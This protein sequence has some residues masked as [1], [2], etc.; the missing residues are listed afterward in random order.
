MPCASLFDPGS[1]ALRDSLRADLVSVSCTHRKLWLSAR[2]D[3]PDGIRA[4][5]GVDGRRVRRADDGR[6]ATVRPHA[7]PTAMSQVPGLPIAACRRGPVSAP[8]AASEESARPTRG[9][10]SSRLVRP[11]S[12]GPGLICINDF[13]TIEPGPGAGTSARKVRAPIIPRSCPTRFPTE[14]WSYIL[15]GM[16]VGVGMVDSLPVGLSA[17]Y[18]VH[19]P[20]HHRRGLGTWNILCL[21]DEARRRGLPHLYLGY[22]VADCLSLAYKSIVPSL[23]NPRTGWRVAPLVAAVEGPFQD[24]RGETRDASAAAARSRVSVSARDHES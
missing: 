17:I 19:D 7:V 6:L 1:R 18:F 13:T 5:L 8:T 2:P 12:R 14:E 20:D 22:W 21:I 24:R 11:A 15:D 10:S 3:G 23:R 16:L 4:C 9:P